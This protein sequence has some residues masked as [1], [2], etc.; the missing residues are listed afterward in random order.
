VDDDSKRIWFGEGSTLLGTAS[1]QKTTI[2]QKMLEMYHFGL[3]YLGIGDKFFSSVRL[4]TEFINTSIMI[5]LNSFLGVHK[6][7]KDLRNIKKRI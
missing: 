6:F 4:S 2:F 3:L 5:N 7:W 1:G